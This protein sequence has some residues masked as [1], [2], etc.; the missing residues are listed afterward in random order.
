MADLRLHA[1]LRYLRK[2]IDPD[3]AGGL[4]DAELL[5]LFVRGRDEAALEALVWRHAPPVLGV[6]RGVLRHEQDAEDAFQATFLILVRKAR[7]IGRSQSVGSWLYT[8]AYRA[9]VQ[10]K[11]TAER[12][13]A[14]EK[15][16][17]GEP[18]AEPSEEV[19]WRDLRPVL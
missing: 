14:R 19:M 15:P 9:A 7:S 2:T 4:A 3:G 17:A 18:A 6:W 10:A 12:R 11:A 8:V 13:A 16:W 5:E 1:V